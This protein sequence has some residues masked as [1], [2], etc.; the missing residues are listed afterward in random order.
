[1]TEYTPQQINERMAKIMGWHKRTDGYW[2]DKDGEL[3]E[4]SWVPNTPN[5]FNSY[6]DLNHANMVLIK[7]LEDHPKYKYRLGYSNGDNILQCLLFIPDNWGTK[8][9]VGS[10]QEKHEAQAI[11]N[12]LVEA[13]KI[14]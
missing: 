2:A 1:M 6:E 3:I 13:T 12:C 5:Y 8:P 11:C 14:S 7:W 10:S 9:F 4:H